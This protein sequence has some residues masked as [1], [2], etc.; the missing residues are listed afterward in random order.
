MKKKWKIQDIQNI[1]DT[2]LLDLIYKAASIH[3]KNFD[4]QKVQLCTLLSVKTG[5]C[6][7]DCSYCSQSS[8]YQTS[9]ESEKLISIDQ[10]I[11]KAKIAKKNGASRFCMGAAW[12]NM[13]K[14]QN[15]KNVLKMIQEVNKLDLQV[16][17]SM[18]MLTEEQAQELKKAGLYAYNHNLDTSPE[19]YKKIITTRSYA[20]RLK[21][22]KAVSRAGLSVCCGCILGLGE[23]IKDR[24]EFI[25]QL[26]RLETPPESIPINVLVP[27]E[28]TPLE[29]N[30]KVNLW[31][32]VRMIATVRLIMPK[33][34]IRL[35]AGRLFFSEVE[36]MLFFMAGANSFF[37]GD[38]LLTTPNN[39]SS[40]D[41]KM[42][43]NLNLVKI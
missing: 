41:L 40:E 15:F 12:R 21:T 19:Y 24:L 4:S 3:R 38:K 17:C 34:M 9:V 31:E 13:T 20:D 27:I 42:L 2:P 28:N 7:E 37:L 22:I 25:R 30:L 6:P 10:V 18:G 14:K 1:Y 26:T 5:N 23:S 43:N 35:S 29:N 33:S 16:C 8:H 32:I 36:Q 39:D 11:E